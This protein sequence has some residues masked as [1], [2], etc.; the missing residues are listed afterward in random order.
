ME[1]GQQSTHNHRPHTTDPRRPPQRASRTDSPASTETITIDD[2]TSHPRRR[3]AG[4]G[5][6]Y[7]RPITLPSQASIVDLTTA[8]DEDVEIVGSTTRPSRSSSRTQAQAAS[9]IPP[10][11]TT[12]LPRFPN[13][14]FEEVIDLEAEPPN[15]PIE[16]DE[17]DEEDMAV[18]EIRNRAPPIVLSSPEV[19][20]ISA[21]DLP[22]RLPSPPPDF[23]Q[24]FVD[25]YEEQNGFGDAARQHGR[26]LPPP[27]FYPHALVNLA[28]MAPVLREPG[29]WPMVRGVV[30]PPM[31]AGGA[32]HHYHNR[33]EEH[34]RSID[35]TRTDQSTAAMQNPMAMPHQRVMNAM[36]NAMRTGLS[37]AGFNYFVREE[38]QPPGP[39]YNPPPPVKAGFTRSPAEDDV[40]VCP[41]C[42]DELCKGS[43]ETKQQAWVV[44][45]CGHVSGAWRIAVSDDH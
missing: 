37:M 34:S 14:I 40:L 42:E 19:T 5:F 18:N 39:A 6:D 7:R 1:A 26:A 43:S 24:D 28:A 21:R 8:D 29:G 25:A 23:D 36:G 13:P 10:R 33:R 15:A 38:V 35:R 30:P 27:Y 20:F 4:D 3:F 31:W 12:R 11:N 22:P 9:R 16:I 32:A 2:T 45:N 41:R 44:K 17:E